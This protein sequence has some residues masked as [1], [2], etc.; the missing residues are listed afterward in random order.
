MIQPAQSCFANRFAARLC[1]LVILLLPGVTW[2]QASPFDTGAN[3]LVS[4]ALTIATPI[5]VLVVI[6]LAIAAAVGR[7]SWGWVI[8]AIL[9]I[10]AIFGSQQIVAWIRSMFGV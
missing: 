6:G 2:A 5:A 3:S 10:A 8:G 7:I 1:V 9:G 4:F